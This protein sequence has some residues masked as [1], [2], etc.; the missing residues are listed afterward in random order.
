MCVYRCMTGRC[1]ESIF[2]LCQK[3]LNV[4]SFHETLISFS[5]SSRLIPD[6]KSPNR[7]RGLFNIVVRLRPRRSNDW[8]LAKG[9]V[10]LHSCSATGDP[11]VRDSEW[12]IRTECPLSVRP[13]SGSVVRRGREKGFTL[14]NYVNGTNRKHGIHTTSTN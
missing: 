8:F 2:S 14:K 5:S 6:P 3:T 1:W 13:V 11:R 10:S 4:L 12:L 9:V 7:L